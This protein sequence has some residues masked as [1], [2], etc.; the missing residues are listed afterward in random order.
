MEM[1][2]GDFRTPDHK[3]VSDWII[4]ELDRI[5]KEAAIA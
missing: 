3:S 5:W 4:D 1:F 2:M